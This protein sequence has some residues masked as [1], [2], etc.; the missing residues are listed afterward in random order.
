MNESI[1]KYWFVE[2]HQE[3][4][5]TKRVSDD[6]HTIKTAQKKARYYR[7]KTGVET[8]VIEVVETVITK[9]AFKVL[10]KYKPNPKEEI[11][12]KD[13]DLD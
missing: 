11:S 12:V 9:K 1:R 6:C 5:Q 4:G 10:N 8:Y 3:N 13:Q 2:A 7:N